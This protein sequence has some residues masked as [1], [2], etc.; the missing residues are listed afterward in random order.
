MIIRLQFYAVEA[1]NII[2]D[3]DKEV[4]QPSLTYRESTTSKE[5]KKF[6]ESFFENLEYFQNFPVNLVINRIS[7]L[8][9]I[10]Y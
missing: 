2:D 1:I 10:P 7:P 3:E 9:L 4:T 5:F 8:I 6:Q